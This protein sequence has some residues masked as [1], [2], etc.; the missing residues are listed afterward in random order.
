M[1]LSREWDLAVLGPVVQP[2]HLGNP[3]HAIGPATT[4]TGASAHLARIWPF[5]PP[6][7]CASSFWACFLLGFDKSRAQFGDPRPEAETS[8]RKPTTT[9]FAGLGDHIV[10]FSGRRHQTRP[11]SGL[12]LAA[13]P[14]PDLAANLGLVVNR[15]WIWP[16]VDLD[17]QPV[18]VYRD[19]AVSDAQLRA[20]NYGSLS[21]GQVREYDAQGYLVVPGL[22]GEHDLAPVRGAMMEK[23]DQ[24]ADQLV[25]GAAHRRP[26]E[27]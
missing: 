26:S 11:T 15:Q 21:P 13:K 27:G 17:C 25:A 22:L 19:Y 7:G 3:S 2:P 1:D 24:I 12:D 5:C 14:G 18:A 16:S 9:P 6:S 20:G 10:P 8:P 4:P 23:V